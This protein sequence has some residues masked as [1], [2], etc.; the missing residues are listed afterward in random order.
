[1][2]SGKN[3]DASDVKAGNETVTK[4]IY[5]KCPKRKSPSGKAQTEVL[6]EEESDSDCPGP[7][8]WK[9]GR[10]SE[11]GEQQAR[12]LGMESKCSVLD[13]LMAETKL[14]RASPRKTR[15]G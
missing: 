8:G 1:M 3:I 5:A 6:H 9:L 7:S 2:Q 15:K 10:G 4:K 12:G 11:Y 14:R 13:D